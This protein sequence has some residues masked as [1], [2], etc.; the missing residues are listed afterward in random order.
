MNTLTR[1][2]TAAAATLAVAMPTAALV[3]APAQADT[4][5]QERCA[6]GIVELSVDREAGR[7][8]VDAQVDNMSA[9]QRWRI[10]L[11]QDGR[12]YFRDVRTT[13]REG[14]LDVDRRRADTSGRDT[15]R[16]KATRLSDGT[17][18]RVAVTVR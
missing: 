9:G 3:A 7:W 4:E 14:E 2:A 12:R 6:G 16:M 17:T 15:F 18:C 13:D 10:V 1:T 11:K 8:E 5:R